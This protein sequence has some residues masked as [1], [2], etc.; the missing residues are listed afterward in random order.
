MSSM[1]FDYFASS[2]ISIDVSPFSTRQYVSPLR[3]VW[4]E[5]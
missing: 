4:T 2:I 5:K 1:Q 3:G